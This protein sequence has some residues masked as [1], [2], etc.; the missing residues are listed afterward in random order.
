MAREKTKEERE[1]EKEKRAQEQ[2][3]ENNNISA[4]AD[5]RLCIQ[6]IGTMQGT[7]LHL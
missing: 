1:K 3:Q 2:A 7:P 5:I 4:I 6:Y